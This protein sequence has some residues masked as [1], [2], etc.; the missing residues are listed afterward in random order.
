MAGK[1]N[2]ILLRLLQALLGVLFIYAGLL[3]HWHPE[4][5]A[6]A[7]RAYQLLPD[8]LVGLVAVVLPWLEMTS[9]LF[10]ILGFKR[11]SCLLILMA[12]TAVFM[13]GILVSLARGLKIDC[14]C[15][16]FFQRQVGLVAALEDGVL[17]A[18]AAA[19]YWRELR[20]ARFTAT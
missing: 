15:G 19:L 11:R 6:E 18:W 5:F 20:Q 16:L 17:L 13:T 12:L 1:L 3:K 9:G 7:V 14:G 2:W 4:E 10:L 8:V